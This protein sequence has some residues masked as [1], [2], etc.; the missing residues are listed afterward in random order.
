MTGHQRRS[1]RPHHN[2]QVRRT[3]GNGHSDR[4]TSFDAVE[5]AACRL[6]LTS[7]GW[8]V[9]VVDPE[10]IANTRAAGRGPFLA[11]AILLH[12]DDS[13]D[14]ARMAAEALSSA[15]GSHLD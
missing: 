8:Y 15:I 11:V 10:P 14:A 2:K 7:D 3:A 9:D 4:A 6:N 12:H 1:R 13:H 5:V